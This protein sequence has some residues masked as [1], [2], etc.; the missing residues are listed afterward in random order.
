MYRYYRSDSIAII[1]IIGVYRRYYRYDSI[2]IVVI[3]MIVGSIAIIVNIG[4]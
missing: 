1:V 2:I 3:G 4:V